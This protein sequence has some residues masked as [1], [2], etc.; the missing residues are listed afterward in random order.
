LQF[1]FLRRKLLAELITLPNVQDLGLLAAA[2]TRAE[3]DRATAEDSEAWQ[4]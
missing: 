2:M 3:R 4:F 1:V